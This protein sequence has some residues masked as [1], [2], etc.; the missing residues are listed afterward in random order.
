MLTNRIV[1]VVRHNIQNGKHQAVTKNITARTFKVNRK[2]VI[3]N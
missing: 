1:P 2:L 3:M